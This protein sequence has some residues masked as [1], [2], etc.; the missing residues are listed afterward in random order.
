MLFFSIMPRDLLIEKFINADA[1]KIARQRASMELQSESLSTT[2]HGF[3]LVFRY[4]H[5]GQCH[6]IRSTNTHLTTTESCTIDDSSARG[7]VATSTTKFNTEVERYSSFVDIPPKFARASISENRK[8]LAVRECRKPRAA[9]LKRS[10][11][12]RALRQTFSR[13]TTA[14]TS[15]A[16]RS[17]WSRPR[18]L[19]SP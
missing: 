9:D 8:E 19:R 10:R 14:E 11:A 17:P 13:G 7:V 18:R 1:P 3:L 6:S 15:P 2:K 16:S 12:R 5:T 4:S